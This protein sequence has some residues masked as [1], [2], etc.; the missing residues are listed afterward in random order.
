MASS[1]AAAWQKY[2]RGNHVD[3]VMKVDS[4]VFECA[5]PYKNHPMNK[6]PAGSAVTVVPE[7]TYNSKA[8]VLTEYNG[9]SI[10]VRVKFD[11][12]SKPGSQ[13]LLKLKP[14]SFSLAGTTNITEYERKLKIQIEERDF[15]AAVR[16]VLHEM[17]KQVCDDK[18]LSPIDLSNVS[19]ADL[20]KII[21]DWPEVLGP[22]YLYY[23]KKPSPSFKY[24]AVFQP[25][26]DNEPLFDFKMLN[27]KIE[28]AFSSKANSGQTN[29]LKCGDIVK[30]IEKNGKLKERW[31]DTVEYRVMVA[32]AE[33]TVLH[34]MINAAAEYKES[35]I[36]T[37][38]LKK[39]KQLVNTGTS[40]CTKLL[41]D[42][43]QL[44]SIKELS[45]TITDGMKKGLLGSGVTAMA[46]SFVC[47]RFL[48]E[49]SKKS[50]AKYSEMFRDCTSG[51]VFFVKFNFDSSGTQCWKVEDSS[52]VSAT[53]KQVY[54]RPKNGFTRAADK[55]GL[56]P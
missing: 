2:F 36:T 7:D 21:T 52:D 35:G 4:P 16:Y 6:I 45:G 28:Y 15:P 18:K 31:K 23:F 50:T 53:A 22:L 9:K 3:T 20:N 33:N 51:Q 10:Q 1:G 29:T 40:D 39:W 37:S 42:L 46:I 13:T 12:I 55:I 27:G 11:S 8:L 26:A 38:V 19:R 43:Q 54:I 14:K 30:I 32:G 47:E 48:Q 41:G 24:T 5:P 25:T 17:T 34:G 44:F 56:Q 49:M